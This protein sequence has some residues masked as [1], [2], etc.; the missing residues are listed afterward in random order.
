M[1]SVHQFLFDELAWP[2]FATYHLCL[3]AAVAVAC[4]PALATTRVFRARWAHRWLNAA[5]LIAITHAVTAPFYTNF[6]FPIDEDTLVWVRM[7]QLQNALGPALLATVFVAV[8]ALLEVAAS[9]RAPPLPAAGHG[10]RVPL[11]SAIRTRQLL[12]SIDAVMA[13]GW[14]GAVALS[15]L[16]IGSGG[17]PWFRTL[18]CITLGCGTIGSAGAVVSGIMFG[19]HDVPSKTTGAQPAP[20]PDAPHAP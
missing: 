10:V 16:V 14:V 6:A 12:R 5:A 9:F 20:A 1:R 3:A 13:V 18:R 15:T 2:S 4:S 7:R 17:F 19:A 11:S 8:V